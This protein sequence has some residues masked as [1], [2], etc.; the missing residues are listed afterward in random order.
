MR[1]FLFNLLILSISIVGTLAYAQNTPPAKTWDARPAAKTLK[2]LNLKSITRGTQAQRASRNS[3]PTSRN[4][5]EIIREGG[6]LPVTQALKEDVSYNSLRYALRID[7]P[8][9]DATREEVKFM[10]ANVEAQAEANREAQLR[11]RN[12]FKLR[13]GK[14]DK[15]TREFLSSKIGKV[16]NKAIKKEQR[17]KEKQKREEAKLKLA[18]SKQK[19]DAPAHSPYIPGENRDN[20]ADK[21]AVIVP[22]AKSKDG[23]A[24]KPFFYK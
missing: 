22:T 7:R 4:P 10:L 17:E 13:H 1:L 12:E 6:D 19:K 16:T 8:Y 11:R 5:I 9:K 21:A 18:A 20:V 24:I 3:G 15:Y 14:T 2:P 23:K